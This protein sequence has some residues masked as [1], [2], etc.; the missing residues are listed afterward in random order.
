SRDRSQTPV[1]DT[2]PSKLKPRK[3]LIKKSDTEKQ[4]VVAPPPEL[5]DELEGDR[6]RVDEEEG[7]KR[8]KGKD[9]GS[10]KKE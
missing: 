7:R 9:I 2:D 8:K 6:F 1:Y 10:G 4:S 5:E 3:R